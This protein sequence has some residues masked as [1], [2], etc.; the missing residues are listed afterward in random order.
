VKRQ[1]RKFNLTEQLIADRNMKEGR[2]PQSNA[3]GIIEIVEIAPNPKA[4]EEIFHT[5]AY[6][7]DSRTYGGGS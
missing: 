2:N 3:I 7:L 1:V 4:I 5:C 6:P